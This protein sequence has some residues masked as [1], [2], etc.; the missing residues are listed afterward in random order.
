MT[1]SFADAIQDVYKDGDLIWVHDYHLTMLPQML[2]NVIPSAKIGFFV[3][4]PFPSSEVRLPACLPLTIYLPACL[5]WV[6]SMP[7][8]YA[9]R[10]RKSQGFLFSS[11]V[12]CVLCVPTILPRRA[13]MPQHPRTGRPPL[14]RRQLLARS[15]VVR[16]LVLA[17]L[18]PLVSCFLFLV[19]GLD[20]GLDPDLDLVVVL[21]L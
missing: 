19:L 8:A 11:W 10:C 12:F 9:H 17:S 7:F 15:F 20:L 1:Q 4:L 5:P 18:S 3:H 16:F 14:V 2:R 21:L 6:F 13:C